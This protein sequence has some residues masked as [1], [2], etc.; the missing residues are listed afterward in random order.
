MLLRSR[1][2]VSGRF[3]DFVSGEYNIIRGRSSRQFQEM[4][5]LPRI[6]GPYFCGLEKKFLADFTILYQ[7]NMIL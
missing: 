5:S 6:L 2:K 7:E 3:R 1:E 4:T